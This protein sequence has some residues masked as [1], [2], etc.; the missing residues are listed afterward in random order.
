[1]Y[2]FSGEGDLKSYAL[3]HDNYIKNIMLR[4]GLIS[5]EDTIAQQGH[6][7]IIGRARGRLRLNKENIF[8]NDSLDI[9]EIFFNLSKQAF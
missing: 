9:D 6:V 2:R 3:K 5:A 7:N 1:M 4:R 8:A